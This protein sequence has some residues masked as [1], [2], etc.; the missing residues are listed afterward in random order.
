MKMALQRRIDRYFG[1]PLCLFL[2]V[3]NQVQIKTSH[4]FKPK[5]IVVILLSEMGGLVLAKPMFDSVKSAHPFAETYLL[6]LKK[7]EEA[8]RLLN[9]V[10]DKNIIAIRDATLT[11]FII[12]SV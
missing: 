5:K 7:N 10:P 3:F 12:D 11:R 9:L 1:T 4:L 6:I 8:A 2:S